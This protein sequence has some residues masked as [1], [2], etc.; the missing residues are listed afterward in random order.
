MIHRAI[1]GS[2][3]R[4]FA[5]LL[6]H[7]KGKLPFWLAPIQIK[8]LTITDEQ[9]AYARTIESQLKKASIRVILDE[10]SDQI[11]AKIK[12]AQLEQVAWMLVIGQK[13]AEQKTVTLRYR[14]GKQ[15]FGVSIDAILEKA[16]LE[17][18]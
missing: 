3:E 8:I 6:E 4:F 17:Q 2:F 16:Q 14:D 1:Y 7:Y 11:S 5:I 15:E 9:D 13:E 10:T 12:R 18:K